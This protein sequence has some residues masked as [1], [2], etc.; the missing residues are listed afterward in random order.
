MVNRWVLAA[1]ALML[2]SC[3]GGVDAD[4]LVGYWSGENGD[5]RFAAVITTSSQMWAVVETDTG[6]GAFKGPVW[7]IANMVAGELEDSAGRPAQIEGR[8]DKTGFPDHEWSHVKGWV[9]ACCV[10]NAAGEDRNR[11]WN[12]EANR[13]A[14]VTINPA[15]VAGRYA[16]ADAAVTITESGQASGAVAGCAFEGAVAPGIDHLSAVV[17]FA[18]SAS[19]AALGLRAE[20]ANGVGFRALGGLFFGAE[21]AKGRGFL[22]YR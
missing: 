4:R 22:L 15:D 11:R 19:C 2:T 12:F 18:D 8:L 3:G 1:S 21:T 14:P 7:N 13:A 5:Q 6:V 9:A 10:K 16:T 20:R 17:Q